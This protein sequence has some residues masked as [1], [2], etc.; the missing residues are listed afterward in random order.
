[1][2]GTAVV[3]LESL[4]TSSFSQVLP[5]VHSECKFSGL[6][7]LPKLGF[8]F[9]LLGSGF[10]KHRKTRKVLSAAHVNAILCASIASDGKGY[11]ADLVGCRIK[12]HNQ[13]EGFVR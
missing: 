6:R 12:T 11:G 4:S 2:P 3:G 7:L 1:M 13:R 10:R 8:R 9:F 5:K